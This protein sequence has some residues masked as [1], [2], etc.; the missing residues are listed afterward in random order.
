MAK[1][2]NTDR[3][4]WNGIVG[5]QIAKDFDST[6]DDVASV[7]AWKLAWVREYCRC[8]ADNLCNME[9]ATI[10]NDALLVVQ[11]AIDLRNGILPKGAKLKLQHEIT[12]E[13]LAEC[14]AWTGNYKLVHYGNNRS[15][16]IYMTSGER[17]GLWHVIMTNDDMADFVSEVKL[18]SSAVTA[19][20]NNNSVKEVYSTLIA[21]LSKREDGSIEITENPDYVAVNNGVWNFKKQE[22]ISFED[23]RKQGLAFTCK[24]RIKYNPNAQN[25]QFYDEK[26]N[27]YHTVDTLVD[28]WFGGDKDHVNAL[29][30]AWHSMLRP[31]CKGF[32]MM[33]LV[34]D[35]KETGNNGKTTAGKVIQSILGK[36]NY[37]AQSL[38]DLTSDSFELSSLLHTNA[39]ISTDSDTNEYIPD[40]NLVKRLPTGDSF[41]MKI[42]FKEPITAYTWHGRLWFTFNG[43]PHF[44]DTS[45]AI[46]RRCYLID[47]SYCFKAIKNVKIQT[48]FLQDE[49]VLEYIL[50]RLLEMDI[51]EYTMYDF[52]KELIG[53]F[54]KAT[55][56]VDEFLDYIT[57]PENRMEG[58]ND[59]AE[60]NHHDGYSLTFLW[61]MF[62]GFYRNNYN[63]DCGMKKQQFVTN[64]RH[65]AARNTHGWEF[66]TE[67]DGTP[68]KLTTTTAMQNNK[69]L[70]IEACQNPQ[71][72]NMANYINWAAKGTTRYM[73]KVDSKQFRG[74]R[75]VGAK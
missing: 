47:F 24:T 72:N 36:E 20:G 33:V 25:K 61:D 1:K 9:P 18:Y 65:W 73:F 49:E 52:Q 58:E 26:N 39:I 53:D 55:N 30:E 27:V 10:A 60:V 22:L 12:T 69:E 37:T 48:E 56:P 34:V 50:K 44:K 5:I 42:K 31:H 14:M 21:L 17:Y 46:D 75:K 41:T 66:P 3:Y 19:G 35:P 28:S 71:I 6:I 63:R 70:F 29:W 7:T 51:R 45:E 8:N 54:R 43:F 4:D 32:M 57:D 64:I 74:I 40:S 13:Q 23:A 15:L 2:D 11:N 38:S 68:K 62:K 59:T 67:G 16:A